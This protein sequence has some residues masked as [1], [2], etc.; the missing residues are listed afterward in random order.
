MMD[1]FVVSALLTNDVAKV[2]VDDQTVGGHCERVSPKRF[3]IAPDRSLIPGAH[4][5][6]RKY[7]CRCYRQQLATN[8]P[9]LG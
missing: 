2:V 6:Q 7:N 1:R 8:G 3:A 9:R 5:Q 4:H